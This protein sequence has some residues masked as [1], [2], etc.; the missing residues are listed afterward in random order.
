[1]YLCTVMDLYS[2]RIIGW[3]MDS[4]MRVGL[5]LKAFDMAH[6]QRNPKKKV[7][8][9]S[10]K[11]GQ[12]KAKVFRKKLKSKGYEQSMTGKDH[13]FDNCF[14][15]S[16]FGTLKRELIRGVTFESREQAETAIFEYIEVFYNRERYHSSLGNMSPANFENIS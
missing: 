6:K 12:Y 11:G 4:N 1:M 8:F 14:A 2:R 15:E 5:L 9:H 13:C 10:D 7:I 3:A 16:F